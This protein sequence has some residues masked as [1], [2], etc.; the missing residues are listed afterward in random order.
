MK[1]GGLRDVGEIGVIG[2][3]EERHY[4]YEA[5]RGKCRSE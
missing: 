2:D 3:V 1:I 5:D 4:E